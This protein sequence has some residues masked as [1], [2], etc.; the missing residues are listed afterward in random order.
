LFCHKSTIHQAKKTT[1]IINF[2]KVLAIKPINA[3]LAALK[4]VVC[5]DLLKINS[6]MKAPKKGPM[7]NPNGI[8]VKMPI[9]KPIFVPHMP[10]LLPPYF[11]VVILGSK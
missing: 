9:I 6:P 5:L 8:G 3:P 4:E 11:L 10:Y 1:L 2:I 7:K